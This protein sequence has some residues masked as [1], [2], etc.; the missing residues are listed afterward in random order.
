MRPDFDAHRDVWGPALAVQLRVWSESF[1]KPAEDLRRLG[2]F[3]PESLGDPPAAQPF[4]G[5]G[6]RIS[7]GDPGPH[8]LAEEPPGYERLR[9]F[10]SSAAEYRFAVEPFSG[11]IFAQV[12]EFMKPHLVPD[13]CLLDAACGP[14][15]EAVAL[16]TEVPDGEVVACDL[17][18][19]MI[20]E[21]AHHGV[22]SGLHNLAFFQRDVENL[23]ADWT[24]A[25][26]AVLCML[27]FHFLLDGAAVADS[28]FRV[29]APGG[30]VFIADPGPAWFNAMSASLSKLANPAFVRYRTGEE[31]RDLLL[32]AGFHSSFWT[33]VLPGIGVAI[34][35]KPEST[36]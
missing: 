5:G 28:F 17:S 15:T 35:T 1:F 9:Q 25:F 11:P 22:E 26:D 27:S 29:L 33:E 36:P 34:V 14:G 21:A 18:Q 20:E 24:G 7:P 32:A 23:P 2:L 3:Q 16:A 31:L 19:A 6:P 30:K 12:L 8:L 4:A 10:E 13:A